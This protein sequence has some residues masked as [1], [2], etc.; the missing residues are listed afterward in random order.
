MEYLPYLNQ[1]TNLV[2]K[3]W[4]YMRSIWSKDD[5]GMVTGKFCEII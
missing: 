4:H 3:K 1:T 2:V 5:F